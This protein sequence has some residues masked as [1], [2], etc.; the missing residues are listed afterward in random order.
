[1]SWDCVP[2]VSIREPL[3]IW[4]GP[5]DEDGP[6]PEGEEAP[7]ESEDEDLPESGEE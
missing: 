4:S 7:P 1:M 3:D 2:E 5:E 6:D